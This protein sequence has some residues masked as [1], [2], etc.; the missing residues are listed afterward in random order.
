VDHKQSAY[1]RQ[2]PTNHQ[3]Y[4]DVYDI[5]TAYEVTNPA[6]AHAVK[7][8]LVPG[9]RS[10]GKTLFEDLSEAE[11]SC[12]R[13]KE[14]EEPPMPELKALEWFYDMMRNRMAMSHKTGWDDPQDFPTEGIIDALLKNLSGHCGPADLADA[15]NFLMMIAYR[16]HGHQL[17]K[18][19]NALSSS[20]PTMKPGHVYIVG[21]DGT[22]TEGSQGVQVE[23]GPGAWT[24]QYP[25]KEDT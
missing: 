15:A 20:Q 12:R 24:T 22:V 1:H 6:I 2:I 25:P 4:S 8:L 9:K 18:A 21:E 11:W 14:L 16:G 3:G 5:L 13:A 23:I 10:G 7:K 17:S 19:I